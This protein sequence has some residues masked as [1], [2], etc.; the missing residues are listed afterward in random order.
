RKIGAP[1]AARLPL[2]KSH[3]R[4]MTR[5]FREQLNTRDPAFTALAGELYAELF[6]PLL[7]K[8]SGIS[9]IVIVPDGV[10]W[11]LPFQALK[12]PKQRYVIEDFSIAY[13][14]SLTIFTEVGKKSGQPVREPSLLAFAS[15]L[16]G[17][18][19]LTDAT[20]EVAGIAEI[21]GQRK[22]VRS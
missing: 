2:T 14:P 16:S 18:R 15:P 21:Y 19:S 11:Q 1:A 5:R 10:L 20:R 6:A 8:L 9:S 4:T 22:L 12:S 13:A 17:P 3:L 7:S